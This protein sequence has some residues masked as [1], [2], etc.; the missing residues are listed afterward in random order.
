MS[1]FAKENVIFDSK[2]LCG[3]FFTAEGAEVSA[4]WLE[5]RVLQRK[6]L[7]I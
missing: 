4:A 5:L 2:S 1:T 7:K 3:W 6:H